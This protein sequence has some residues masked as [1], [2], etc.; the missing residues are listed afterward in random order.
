[1][2]NSNYKMDPLSL[3][4]ETEDGKKIEKNKNRERES[5][6]KIDE[7]DD[8]MSILR[9]PGTRDKRVSRLKERRNELNEREELLSRMLDEKNNP[10]IKDDEL[11]EHEELLSRML[12]EK[13]NP[14]IKDESLPIESINKTK[15][16]SSPI[17]LNISEISDENKKSLRD[18]FSLSTLHSL[19]SE[20]KKNI[21]NVIIQQS[22]IEDLIDIIKMGRLAKKSKQ[23]QNEETRYAVK[24]KDTP[25]KKN[26]RRDKETIDS[27]MEKFKK[28]VRKIDSIMNESLWNQQE[29]KSNTLQHQHDSHRTYL[30]D[31]RLGK[32]NKKG[33]RAE[34]SIGKLNNVNYFKFIQGNIDLTNEY[35]DK[36]N[37]V[38]Y[39]DTLKCT[40][41]S[42]LKNQIAS[43]SFGKKYIEQQLPQWNI[44][45]TAGSLRSN[46][47]VHF[48]KY[49][50]RAKTRLNS[51]CVSFITFSMV[52]PIKDPL[53]PNSGFWDEI[54]LGFS[55]EE[56]NLLS[57]F[58]KSDT[59]ANEKK[60]VQIPLHI[61]EDNF[62]KNEYNNYTLEWNTSMISLRVNDTLVYT[63]QKNHPVPQLPGYTYFIVRPNYNTDNI[64]LLKKIK[65]I[66]GKNIEEPNIKIK[67]FSYDPL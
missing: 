23:S 48:G 60:Q 64:E 9:V 31:H 66:K 61:T 24:N 43:R 50:V 32:I 41:C 44:T 62:N 22:S 7:N 65:G 57:L 8:I 49:N 3:V 4:I 47:R 12:D 56:K 55:S 30:F 6:K 42:Q 25:E 33:E 10:T 53:Y 34:C 52:L 39:D 20:M 63:T 37:C 58:I 40:L 21:V 35:Q 17:E 27:L 13:N 46:N 18:N 11:N 38:S 2:D 54:A 59:T 29:E 28:N 45:F 14:T 67:S 19:S 5:K 15:N 1:M 16:V 51:K 26:N 36:C